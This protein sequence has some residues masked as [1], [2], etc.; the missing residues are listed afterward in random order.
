M[1]NLRRVLLWEVIRYI[2]EGLFTLEW[3]SKIMKN[4]LSGDESYM[5][6]F[7]EEIY[8]QKNVRSLSFAEWKSILQSLLR[9]HPFLV[10]NNYS[11]Q[12][13]RYNVED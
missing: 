7:L 2:S 5:H 4:S 3:V 6:W 11:S 9:S 8:D 13:I 10:W 12:L 1:E